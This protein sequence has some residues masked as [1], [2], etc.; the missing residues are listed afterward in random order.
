M[1]EK[2]YEGVPES[3]FS[4]LITANHILYHNNV[5]DGFG[6]V[7]VRNP[8]DPSTFF[9][10]GSIAPAL[11]SSLDDLIEYNVED[12]SPVRK[13]SGRGYAE[14]FIHSEIYKKY[15]DVKSVCWCGSWTLQVLFTTNVN[16]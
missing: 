5:C 9:L 4:T 2:A 1:A 14:R 7:S 13:D 16:G 8:A 12:A 10:S 11:V 3:I 15:T 6:H